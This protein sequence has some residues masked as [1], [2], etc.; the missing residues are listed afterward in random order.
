MSR[1]RLNEW[2]M[3]VGH[4][5]ATFLAVSGGRTRHGLAAFRRIVRHG[6]GRRA[7]DN[8]SREGSSEECNKNS[9][10]ESHAFEA[11]LES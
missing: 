1:G 4:R 11:R 5:L 8:V 2:S 3:D 6:G 7:I 9:S 10:T